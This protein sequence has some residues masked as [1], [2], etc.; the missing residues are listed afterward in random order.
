MSDL[1]E[2][3]AKTIARDLGVQEDGVPY[4]L[5]DDLCANYLSQNHADFGRLARAA[6]A[7][8][9]DA[10]GEDVSWDVALAGIKGYMEGDPTEHFNGSGFG[11]KDA[12]KAML[13]QFKAENIDRP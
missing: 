4:N 2:R 5:D 8:V 13:A 9:L 1:V 11:M 3:V 7:E 12:F 6:I 10:M